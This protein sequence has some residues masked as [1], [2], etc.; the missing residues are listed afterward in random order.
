MQEDSPTL[1]AFTGWTFE[2]IKGEGWTSAIHRDDREKFLSTWR[3]AVTSG[4]SVRAEVR[5]WN[6]ASAAWHWM[7]LRAVPIHDQEGRVTGWIGMNIDVDVRKRAEVARAQMATLLA[8]HEE[9]RRFAQFLHDDLQQVLYAAQLKVTG[10]ST[11]AE[12]DP[13]RTGERLRAVLGL[14]ENA[15]SRTRQLSVELSPPD[16]AAENLTAALRAVQAEMWELHDLSVEVELSDSRE[17][18]T[19]LCAVLLQAVRELLFNVTKHAGTD[20]AFVK[21]H[22]PRA[23]GTMRI[24][25]GDD[26]KG[27]HATEGRTGTGGGPG[28]GLMN[29][30]QRLGTLG[31]RL[32]IDSRPGDGARITLELPIPPTE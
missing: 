29:L 21:V 14:L 23:D 8:T 12:S 16:Q 13:A 30:R 3:E 26:G 19:E 18:A 9:Q 17:I 4:V 6:A 22:A 25:V 7:E 2:E 11:L 28:F 5:L 10:A 32:D 1:R 31:G 24:T 27:F 20:R 15:I